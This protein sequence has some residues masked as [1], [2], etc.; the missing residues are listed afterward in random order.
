MDFIYLLTMV[1]M[2]LTNPCRKCL[3]RVCCSQRCKEVQ[4]LWDLGEIIINRTINFIITVSVFTITWT[5]LS[6]ILF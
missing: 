1:K 6:N 3:V 5:V 2:K 4:D